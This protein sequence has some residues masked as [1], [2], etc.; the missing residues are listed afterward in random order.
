[1]GANLSLTNLSFRVFMSSNL[2]NVEIWENR[3][4]GMVALNKG[5]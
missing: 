5:L 4:G 2:K 1:M 3:V